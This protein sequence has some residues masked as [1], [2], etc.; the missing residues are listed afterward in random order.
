MD[1]R[2]LTING[3]KK[4]E[5]QFNEQGTSG[6]GAAGQQEWGAQFDDAETVEAKTADE[7]FDLA[8]RFNTDTRPTEVREILK[9]MVRARLDAVDKG[10]IL[11]K[12]SKKTKQSLV[13][14]RKALAAIEHPGGQEKRDMGVE[15]FNKVL[16]LHFAKGKHILRYKKQFWAWAGSHWVKRDDEEISKLVSEFLTAQYPDQGT[17]AGVLDQTMK[18]MRSNLVTK[19]DVFRFSEKPR[20]IIN[21]LNG[22]I[23][24]LPDG[25]FVFRGEHNPEN[26]QIRCLEFAYD[27][28]ATCAEYDKAL[29]EIWEGD[30]EIVRHWHEFKGYSIQAHRNIPSFWMLHGD[31]DN[32]K[33]Q[34]M[35]TVTRLT[36]QESVA[37]IKV[38][39]LAEKFAISQL[40]GKLI[41][42][43]DDL[44]AKT[45]LPD[46]TIKQLSEL[47]L[48][49][50][51]FKFKDHYGFTCYV[52][53]VA[54]CNHWPT[55]S[56]L[57]H[58]MRKR[59]Y[60]FPFRRKFVIGKDA[61]VELFPR[62]W[63]NEMSGVLNRALEGLRL[64]RQR[65]KFDEPQT[66]LD[67]KAEWLIE[68][69]HVRAFYEGEF[70]PQEGSRLPA[71]GTF[72]HYKEW[73]RAHGFDNTVSC[74]KLFNDL[75][76]FGLREVKLNGYPHWRD[77]A[78]A[79]A[80]MGTNY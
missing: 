54:L 4:M 12:I 23:H 56:D 69:N 34:L 11:T 68:A 50:A 53:I 70:Y 25:G 73:A 33:T 61:D 5:Q 8:S 26:Y 13:E 51:E 20:P 14:L 15:T 57:S 40:L 2:T 45:H 10:A 52:L 29:L 60:I 75:R 77:V 46:G 71:K 63:A 67:A 28:T 72:K 58:G 76:G 1:A 27:P 35:K 37:A 39:K 78:L 9:E 59:V 32:G 47:K 49:T 17:V 24:L 65:G 62:I 41:A 38:G 22:E 48:M 16:E 42:L 6:E 21:V 31:G 74:K 43:D 44:D 3:R 19:E 80:Q 55:T 18:L 66:C 7:L 36:G 64:L 79:D 30:A